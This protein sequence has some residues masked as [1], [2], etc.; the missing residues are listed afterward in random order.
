[1]KAIKQVMKKD[2]EP[3]CNQRSG[4]AY[5]VSPRNNQRGK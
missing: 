2:H 3:Y 5:E 4:F 1:M